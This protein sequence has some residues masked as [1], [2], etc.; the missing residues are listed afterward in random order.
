MKDDAVWEH[1]IEKKARRRYQ[2]AD[3]DHYRQELEVEEGKQETSDFLCH[4]FL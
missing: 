2:T 3:S 1:I 4:L